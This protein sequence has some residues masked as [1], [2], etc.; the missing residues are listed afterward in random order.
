MTTS[1]D[2][3]HTDGAAAFIEK[4]PLEQYVAPDK[5][6]LVGL[7]RDAL[8]AALGTIGVPE[9]QQ[10][11]R[12]QQIWHWLYVR[13]EQDFDAMTTLSKELRR[14]GAPFHDGAAGGRRRAGLRRRHAQVAIAASRRNR[15]PAL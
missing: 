2:A 14:A 15:Q 11:M 3:P 5:P 13:G 12:V 1:L 7:S 9:R 6:S 8:A 4:R 10:R